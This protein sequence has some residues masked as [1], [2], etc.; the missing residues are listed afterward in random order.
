V[1]D[2]AWESNWVGAPKSFQHAIKF[3]ISVTKEFT[4]TAGKV[5]PVYQ[6]TVMVVR[7]LL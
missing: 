2:A 3:I 6:S 7:I 5:I 1:R 4:L